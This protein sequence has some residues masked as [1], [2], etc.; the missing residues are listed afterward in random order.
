MKKNMKYLLII[1]GVISIA[2]CS[3]TQ[4]CFK[5]AVNYKTY[6]YTPNSGRDTAYS[7]P[8]DMCNVSREFVERFVEDH[9]DTIAIPN[10]KDIN[11]NTYTENYVRDV[12]CERYFKE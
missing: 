6:Q 4:M 12:N 7:I 9:T 2:S 8:E 11:G 5:C 3:K 10:R 1:F